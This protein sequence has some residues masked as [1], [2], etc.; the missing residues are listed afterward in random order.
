[1]PPRSQVGQIFKQRL[2]FWGGGHGD[3][4][5]EFPLDGWGTGGNFR[6]QLDS[7]EM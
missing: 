5:G 7:E 3:I 4:Q 1:M 2:D 6:E